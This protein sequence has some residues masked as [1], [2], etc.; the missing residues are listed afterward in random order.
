MVSSCSTVSETAVDRDSS[1]AKKY[2]FMQVHNDIKGSPTP[3]IRRQGAAWGVPRSTVA[4]GFAKRNSKAAMERLILRQNPKHLATVERITSR[5]PAAMAAETIRVTARLM[6]E[7]ERVTVS[8]KM[9]KIS[10]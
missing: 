6:P 3:R 4:A 7:V 9:E 2:P 1:T 8:M 5:R 10:W